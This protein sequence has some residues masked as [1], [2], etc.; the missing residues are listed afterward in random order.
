MTKVSRAVDNKPFYLVEHR[1]VRLIRIAT[2]CPPR[3]ND[4]D[5]RLLGEHRTH[6][7]RACVGAQELACPSRAGAKEESIVQISCRMIW[8]KIQLAEIIVIGL[9]VWAFGNGETQVREN[10][11]ELVHD[12]AHG[13]DPPCVDPVR[14]DW[15]SGI[16]SLLP[17]TFLERLLLQ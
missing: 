9:D 5:R 2:V 3:T 10:D 13:M 17:E 4:A 8:G 11:R 15:Q 14:R 12:L 6:L 1:R 16:S 7:N